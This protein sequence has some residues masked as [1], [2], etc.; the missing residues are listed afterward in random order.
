MV[1]TARTEPTD[2]PPMTDV[3]M[4]LQTLVESDRP[5]GTADRPKA[6]FGSA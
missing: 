5:R 6:S 3:T 2:E 1:G 4:S